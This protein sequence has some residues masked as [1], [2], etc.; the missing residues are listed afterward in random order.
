MKFHKKPVVI[1]AVD[2]LG[3]Y[4]HRED[5]PDWFNAAIDSGAMWLD[6]RSPGNLFINTLEGTH[7][8]EPGD[9]IIQGVKGELYPC[10]P[11]IFALTYEAVQ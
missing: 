2:W 9:K 11:D 6:G 1:E 8:A 4:T 3:K 7:R 5:W 10:K